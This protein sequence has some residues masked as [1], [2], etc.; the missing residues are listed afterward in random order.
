MAGARFIRT[1]YFVD[2]MS[3]PEYGDFDIDPDGLL[4]YRES[5][6]A[7]KILILADIQ[8]KYAK[9]KVPRPLGESAK[10]AF[11]KGADALV[12]T[13][14]ASG[15]APGVTDL[16]AAACTELPVLVGSGLRPDNARELLAPCDG[17]I[18]GTSLMVNGSVDVDTL[19]LLISH[20]KR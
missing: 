2:D 16:Q 18:V 11:Q 19:E 3:R 13:G 12:V 7:E 6:G 9:M 8:V 17:A 5:I 4:A 14:N 1:D 15:D 10:L 20:V